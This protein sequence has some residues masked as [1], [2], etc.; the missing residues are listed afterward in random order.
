MTNIRGIKVLGEVDTNNSSSTPLGAGI[1]FTGSATEILNEGIIFIS[2]FSNV[3]SATDG[4]SIQQSTDGTNWDH[5]D[6]YTVPANSGKNYAINPHAQYVRVVYTNGGTLQTSFRL[7]TIIKGNALPSSH[8]IQDSIVDDDDSRLVKSVLSAKFNGAGFGN[9]TATSSG[10]LRVANAEDGLSIAMGDV[11]D[12]S[13]IHK[14]GNAPDFDTGDSVVSVWDGADDAN[15]D[16]MTYQYSSSADIDSL[17][18]SNNGD[19]QDIEIQG[20]DSSYDVVTQTVTLT[21]QTRAALGTSLIRVFRMVNVNSTDNAGHIYCYVNSAI[22]AGVPDDS[23][24]VRA[25]IQPGNNQTL[26]AIYTIPAGF[27]GYMRNWFAS[28]AG[29]N[30]NSNYVIQVRARPFGEVFQLKHLS[31]ISDNGSSAIQHVYEEPEVFAEKTDIE[32]RT[33][34]LA[35]GATGATV[36]AGF[37]IVLKDD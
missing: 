1:A 8:R 27:T 36:S 15:I 29:A 7:Q 33:Q 16:Q 26:M 22:T 4:L 23:T 28:T 20:L 21:G 12:T 17:S 30:K 3:A 2:V 37:D 13:F 31:A 18:S 10:N 19:T 32:I 14:F 5:S 25:V 35:I 24:K 9:I 34:V 6:V 11:V